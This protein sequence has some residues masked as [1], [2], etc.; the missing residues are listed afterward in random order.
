LISLFVFGPNYSFSAC[1]FSYR[2][3]AVVTCVSVFRMM[4]VKPSFVSG[5]HYT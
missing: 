1:R 2:L 5:K 4:L 3:V